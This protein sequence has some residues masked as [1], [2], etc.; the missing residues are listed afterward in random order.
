MRYHR[1][2]KSL[3]A[4]KRT[5]AFLHKALHSADLAHALSAAQRFRILRKYASLSPAAILSQA[6]TIL[7]KEGLTVV[8]LEKGYRSWGHLLASIDRG[9][10]LGYIRLPREETAKNRW[11]RL[12]VEAQLIYFL[13]QAHADACL[14]N[15]WLERRGVSVYLRANRARPLGSA[16]SYVSTLEIANWFMKEKEWEAGRL[17][18]F[19]HLA[20][21]LNAGQAVYV[22]NVNRADLAEALRKDG[23]VQD[24]IPGLKP[25]AWPSFYRLREASQIPTDKGALE[26]LGLFRELLPLESQLLYGIEEMKI[27]PRKAP[28]CLK[29]GRV[30]VSVR[31]GMQ[32]TLEGDWIST[33]DITSWSMPAREWSSGRFLAFLDLAERLNPQDA[34]YVESV[35]NAVLARVLLGDGWT[36][37]PSPSGS[38]WPSFYRRRKAFEQVARTHYRVDLRWPRD[39]GFAS[40]AV[41]A[42]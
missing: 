5:A 12:P 41:V 33:L 17:L 42:T 18:A 35:D 30:E 6:D 9:K 27:E 23:W 11:R 13:E 29:E 15:L 34:V 4:L 31:P 37:I 25:V 40:P 14:T 19:I 16:W 1:L 26:R 24:D 36:E 22:E 2:T 21:R 10:S 32:R 28:L 3:G 7:R 8:A 39:L 38:V 20:E